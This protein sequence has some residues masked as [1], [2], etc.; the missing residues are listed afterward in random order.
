[1][2]FIFRSL[3]DTRERVEPLECSEI[4]MPLYAN[5]T[6]VTNAGVNEF[7]APVSIAERGHRHSL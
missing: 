2:C 6:A 5:R 4:N 3:A 7:G 1:V